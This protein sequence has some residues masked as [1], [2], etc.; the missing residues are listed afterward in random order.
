MGHKNN[1]NS[2]LQS[3][4]AQ[5][6][7]GNYKTAIQ[8]L[9]TLIKENGATIDALN[10][11]AVAYTYLNDFSTALNIL[12]DII[13]VDPTE[14]IMLANFEYLKTQFSDDEFNEKIITLL[15]QKFSLETKS[16]NPIGT[17]VKRI[18]IVQAPRWNINQPALAVGVLTGIMRGNNFTVFPHD[19][20]IDF[21][22]TANESDKAFW[23]DRNETFWADENK[24]SSLINKYPTFQIYCLV[25]ILKNNPQ[26]VG[27]S[28][29]S[30]SRFLSLLFA[31]KIKKIRPDIYIVLG[32]PET[33]L[34]SKIM[35]EPYPFIDAIFIGEA[36]ISFPI[37]TK[38]L[39]LQTKEC[40]ITPGVIYRNG[41]GE[42]IDCGN[43]EKLPKV[44]DIMPAD[45]SDIDF[46]KYRVPNSV[47]LIMSRGCVN[48]CSFCNEAPIFK[49]YR[50]YKAGRAYEEI[51]N[52]IKN[53]N[54]GPS[55]RIS[56][57]DSLING[58][59]RDLEE[60]CDLLIERPI[61]GL[62]FSGM[63]LVRKQMTEQLIEKL[64]K[65]GL[66]EVFL[67]VE[68][69]SREVLKIM[70]KNFDLEDVERIVESMSRHGIK[71]A[72]FFMV[73]HPGESEIEFYNSL[74]FMRKLAQNAA[75]FSVNITQILE[76]SDINKNPEKYNV[77]DI[78]PIDWVADNGA[79][80]YEVRRQRQ[81]ISR[82]LLGDKAYG[83]GDF[84]DPTDEESKK[85]YS[86]GRRL[87]EENKL[88][89]SNIEKIGTYTRYLENEVAKTKQENKVQV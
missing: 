34:G 81:L 52:V 89:K 68:T 43:V 78:K 13:S 18:S 20:D 48:R 61:E 2:L 26:L 42:I 29:Q 59:L 35:L 45:F 86:Q 14:E 5:I 76:N 23:E 57:N 85:Y 73:G 27:F 75:Q 82:T 6:N 12:I 4:E 56:Y 84:E 16:D 25:N 88:F 15:S 69:G 41:N 87:F 71:V 53:T 55:P 9:T 32:G 38:T 58:N 80:T 19:F 10:D 36:D 40:A 28:V 83:M 66:A 67:G 63:M 72:I 77:T 7:K 22:H 49:R 70:R 3:A 79:N 39:N 44:E 17:E 33:S 8:I 47:N 50:S 62:T 65:A 51:I 21:F 1:S 30:K 64:A 54:I 60:F 46:Q 11:L 24:V 74:N 37:F 31:E